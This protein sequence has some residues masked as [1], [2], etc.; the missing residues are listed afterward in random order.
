MTIS[1]SLGVT[2]MFF[3]ALLFWETGSLSV[4]TGATQAAAPPPTTAA[5]GPQD[6]A[7]LISWQ[8]VNTDQTLRG[9]TSDYKHRLLLHCRNEGQVLI[10]TQGK[11]P[12]SPHCYEDLKKKKKKSEANIAA[13]HRAEEESP[14]S[15][16][17]EKQ[18]RANKASPLTHHI[19]A[20]GNTN[21]DY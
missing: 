12:A 17:A 10:T 14:E 21:P 3:L 4:I 20:P 16:S 6:V 8:H 11:H 19:Q 18:V 7:A 9:D 5:T 1:P 13:C 15:F 2:L